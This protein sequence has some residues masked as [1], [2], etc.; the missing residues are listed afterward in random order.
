M[1]KGLTIYK[2]L[3]QVFLVLTLLEMNVSALKVHIK[4]T[5]KQPQNYASP[6]V[7]GIGLAIFPSLP[8]WNTH[9]SFM[10]AQI[11]TELGGN[12]EMH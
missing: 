6:E 4:P 12:H 5:K 7:V 10:E 11:L 3:C 8:L 9:S 1:I 2:L